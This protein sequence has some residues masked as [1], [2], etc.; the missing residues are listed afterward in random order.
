MTD[1]EPD[2]ARALALREIGSELD[3]LITA[4][5]ATKLA[6]VQAKVGN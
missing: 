4:P 5:V 3:E 6:T 1:A 2:E